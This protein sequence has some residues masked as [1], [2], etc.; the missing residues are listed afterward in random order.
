M[1]PTCCAQ[2]LWNIT[3]DFSTE[4]GD[5][6]QLVLLRKALALA[7]M[8]TNGAGFPT[9][10]EAAKQELATEAWKGCVNAVL[11]AEQDAKQT[12]AQQSPPRFLLLWP[13]D[14]TGHPAETD[15]TLPLHWPRKGNQTPAPSLKIGPVLDGAQNKVWLFAYESID[16]HVALT[17]DGDAGP[18]LFPRRHPPGARSLGL[19]ARPTATVNKHQSAWAL[20]LFIGAFAVSVFSM[21]WVYGA[22]ELVQGAANELLKGVSVEESPAGTEPTLELKLG[23]S[24]VGDLLT[25]QV[26]DARVLDGELT[27]ARENIQATKVKIQ[28]DVEELDALL[29]SS[30]SDTPNAN[31]ALGDAAPAP[32]DPAQRSELEGVRR[33]L[34]DHELEADKL[35]ARAAELIKQKEEASDRATTLRC[36]AQVQ[37]RMNASVGTFGV[38]AC[39]DALHREWKAKHQEA[40]N[41]SDSWAKF[42]SSFGAR[43]HVR[44]QVS[45]MWPL[46]TSTLAVLLLILSAG[47][48][49]K[50]LFFGAII[51]NRNRFSLS[52]LQQLSW[53]V[54]LFGGFTILGVFNIALLADF[55]RDVGQL[56]AF[57][58]LSNAAAPELELVGLF[59][60]MD[61]ALWAVLGITVAVS[62]YISKHILTQKAIPEG[63]KTDVRNVEAR[64]VKP[65][66]LDQRPA[67]VQARWADLFTGEGKANA[68]Q[69]DVSR[70]QHLVITLLLLGGYVVLLVEF[71]RTLDAT[72]IMM[73]VLTGAPIFAAMPPVDATFVGLLAISHVGY[74]AFKAMPSSP[75]AG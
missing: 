35:D 8:A 50:G 25:E 18:G 37:A 30:G 16:T 34:K 62:P 38:R 39:G 48:A 41:R 32:T 46:A 20:V 52:R 19:D 23:R 70:L 54:V 45:L 75:E 36:L 15:P 11:A 7:I 57:A 66:P 71:V 69:V 1:E 27:K 31:E 63:A 29:T 67:P 74:L 3:R 5:T 56:Q 51:D 24:S 58:D 43:T 44:E 4:T 68:K 61:P 65:D 12:P 42:L 6:Q 73:A 33:R 14:G 22:A 26:G 59:P 17:E 55:A 72:A 28:K 21:A 40:I 10:L 64:V 60:S 47:I 9:P 2:I 49:L 53:T 13:A